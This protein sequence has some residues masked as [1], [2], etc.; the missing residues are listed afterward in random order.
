MAMLF[1]T[2]YAPM[3]HVHTAAGEGSLVHAHLPEIETAE[4]E[5]AVH[6]ERP[7]S[8]AAARPIDILTTTT[9]RSVHLDD[10]VLSTDL[11]QEMSPPCCGFI[12]IAVPRAHGP[13]VVVA[14]LIPRAPPA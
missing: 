9:M 4:A 3:F 5:N 11:I 2:F 14:L 8:H 7:H 6:M 12:S 1:G 10:V 13:P